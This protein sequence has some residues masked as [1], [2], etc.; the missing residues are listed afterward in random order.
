MPLSL[1]FGKQGKKCCDKVLSFHHRFP[2][3]LPQTNLQELACFLS[4]CNESFLHSHSENSLARI[5]FH[6]HHVTLKTYYRNVQRL[7]IRTFLVNDTDLGIAISLYSPNDLER[8]SEERI[9]RSALNLVT[10]IVPVPGSYFSYKYRFSSLYYLEIKKIRAPSFSKNERAKLK[11]ELLSDLSKSIK[12]I[13]QS[14]FL[15][16]NEE[17]LIKNTRNLSNELRFVHDI[18]QVMITFVE[19]F[20]ETLKFLV[21]VTRVMKP[22]CASISEMSSSLPSCVQFS[23]EKV[24]HI[25]TLRNKYP[26]EAAIFHLELSCS[27]FRNNQT[28]NIRAARL[29]VVKALQ[30]MLGPFRD[31]NGGLLNK[32]NEQLYAIKQTLEANAIDCPAI[33]DL[34][35]SIK[36]LELR[37]LMFL[38]TAVELVVNFQKLLETPLEK[39][40]DYTT[41]L[42]ERPDLHLALIKTP[43][44][45]WRKTLPAT[46]LAC[47]SKI[48]C[49]VVTRE[50]N[51]YI[52]FFHQMPEN[53]A[54]FTVLD[55][56]LSK[57]T[58][59][60][61][62]R[63]NAILHLN[64]QSGDPL[65]LNPHH[66]VDMPSNILSN[67][68]FEGLTGKNRQPAA[69]SKI[70]ISP[71]G[72]QYTFSLRPSYW[73]N[74]SQ[75]LAG[76]FEKAWKKVLCANNTI[77]PYPDFFFLIKNVKKMRQ[78]LASLEDIGIQCKDGMTLC[79]TLEAPCPWFLDLLSTPPFFPRLDDGEEPA[80][81]NGPFTVVA[82]KH[83]KSLH[84]SQNPFY[85]SAHQIKLGGVKISMIQSSHLYYEMFKKGELDF[86]GDPSSPLTPDLV[87]CPEV[88]AQIVQKQISRIFWI[89]CN[90]KTPLLSHKLLR[91]ALS[92]ALNRKQI[93][94]KVLLHQIPQCSPLPQQ[95]AQVFEKEEGNP[96]LARQLFEQGLKELH[97]DRKNL[98]QLTLTYSALSFEKALFEELKMQWKEVLGVELIAEQ[99]RWHEFS[100]ALEKGN[101]QLCG[102]FRRDLFNNPLYYLSFFK[103]TPGNPYS[104]N[105]AEYDRLVQIYAHNPTPKLLKLLE[106]LLLEEMPVIPLV[107]QNLLYLIAPNVEGITWHPNGL[108]D[109]RETYFV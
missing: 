54:L 42:I 49:S 55:Q 27:L 77:C 38:E 94:E 60:S 87:M 79:I 95:Y 34:F 65:S 10:G 32:E 53:R 24:Q 5:F 7:Y 103:S 9:F 68:L 101:F 71:C 108:P 104:L 16:G 92:L 37:T 99:V 35:Y 2:T 30:S 58:A 98:P 21:I 72:T 46:V 64:F 88:Q 3:L 82:Y 18:P 51:L 78:N 76:H 67:M 26:K 1:L 19:Y 47:N 66:A 31:Y 22:E 106:Q 50:E 62:D 40:K 45:N 14:F 97:L 43:N 57:A 56:A 84:L 93:V 8:L 20:Q 44:K 12:S 25:G 91:H 69:A 15:P 109:F 36:P 105:N 52:C 107:N 23:L 81:F 29:Y 39:D 100:E 61:I 90:D 17:E 28:L 74:G 6:L 63:R 80:A 4:H 75:V 89:H 102:L 33:E 13:S 70:E 48:G 86:I 73:S 41:I 85:H 11:L 96:E 83:S 59:L